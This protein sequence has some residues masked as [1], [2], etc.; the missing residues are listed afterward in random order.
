MN[1]LFFRD[2]ELIKR[3]ERQY[4]AYQSMGNSVIIAGPGSGKTRIL[5]LKAI[6]LAKSYIHKPCG[7]ACISYS[8]ESVRE[9]KKRLRAYGYI[10]SNKDFI[11]TVHSFSLLHVI[12]P[13]AHLYPQYNVQYPIKILPDDIKASLYNSVL[14]ELNIEDDRELPLIDINKH[15]SLSLRGRSEFFMDSSP[16]IAKAAKL[17]EKKINETEFIDFI[18]IINL[19]A[20][21]INEQEYV[22][23]TIRSQFP[24]LLVDEYQDLGKALH[25]MVLELVFNADIKLYAVGDTNQSIYGFNGGYPDFLVELTGNDNINT[26]ELI[27]NYRSTQHI[28]NASR[29]ALQPTLPYPDYRAGNRRDEVADFTFITCDVG[30]EPQ[31]EVVAKKVIPNLLAKGIPR[32]EIGIITSSNEKI[33]HMAHYMQQEDIPFFIVNWSFENSE[34]VVW[35]QDCALWCTDRTAQSFEDLYRIWKKKILDSHED[36]RKDWEKIR[37]KKVFYQVLVE[38]LAKTTC[39]EWLNYIIDNLELKNSLTGSKIYPNE[40]ENLNKLLNET[41]LGN[42]KNANIQRFAN[43]G[44][45]EDQVTITTRHSSK[46]LEFEAVILLG[47]EEDNFPHYTH[48][49]NPIALAEDQRLCYV[50]ISRAKKSCILLRSTIYNIPTRRGTIWEKPF[51]P[52][53][54]WVSLHRMFGNE[55]NTFTKVNYPLTT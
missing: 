23:D 10:P 44:F 20:R 8:R 24:W 22:R 36:F 26:I 7:L 41:R 16:Q 4:E 15:R 47:M 19:S 49:N 14:D 42:L 25:E 55:E 2:L 5:T 11:G 31:F 46:G 53:R 38:S 6:T 51:N 32:N 12:Q 52:S 37:L 43:L 21:I 39:Y 17:Y 18:N 29:E 50:C 34:I 30:I 40:V 3:D 33:H 28:I 54:F 45:P 35:L 1:S 13:F 27:S 9:L 48:L